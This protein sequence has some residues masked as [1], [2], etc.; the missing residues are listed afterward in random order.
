[1]GDGDGGRA[2]DHD[3]VMIVIRILGE[4]DHRCGAD[5]DQLIE[6]FTT[7][8]RMIRNVFHRDEVALDITEGR[9]FS[10]GN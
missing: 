4:D 7:V 5:S 6:I 8:I 10:A 9:M 2:R 3:S 1:M